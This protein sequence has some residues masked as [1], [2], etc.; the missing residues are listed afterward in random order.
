MTVNFEFVSVPDQRFLSSE[1]ID[2]VLKATGGVGYDLSNHAYIIRQKDFK[3]LL[4]N[5][6]QLHDHYLR[7]EEAGEI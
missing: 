4:N 2:A 3:R 5:A 6:I 7:L 1:D